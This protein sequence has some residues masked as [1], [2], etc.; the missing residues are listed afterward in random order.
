MTVLPTSRPAR[1]LLL[2]L[3]L[4]ALS[5]T[6]V[7]CGSDEPDRDA[8][9][10]VEEA[11][12]L[13]V[14]RFQVG[15]CFDDPTDASDITEVDAV[16][17]AQAHDNQV[18]HLFDVPGGDFPGQAELQSMAEEGCMEAFEGFVGVA[19]EAS[20]LGAAPI[21]PSED[22][23]EDGDHEV[24]CALFDGAGEQLTGS[25]EGSGADED[26]AGQ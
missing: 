4:P 2:A 16:P 9:G 24:V 26:A 1:R 18:F 8:S 20:P 25:A 17:C 21:V 3:A 12:D 22:S 15:D 19:F 5:L 14:D 10:A 11:G 6:A 7:A 23:W 13:G